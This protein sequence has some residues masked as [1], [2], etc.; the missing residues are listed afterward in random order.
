VPDSWRLFFTRTLEVA[1]AIRNQTC[2]RQP[3]ILVVRMLVNLT[4]RTD[5][6]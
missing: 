3:I 1:Q 4:A 6:Q 5:S 2:L